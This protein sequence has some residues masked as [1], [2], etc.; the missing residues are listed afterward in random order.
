MKHDVLVI[1]G[2]HAGCE[3]AAA[4]A[5][6]GARVALITHDAKTIGAMS[7]NPSI[8]GVG[9]G[10]LVRE[11]DALDGLIARAGDCAAIHY[12]M[13]NRSKGAAVRGPRIQ[14][15]RRAF[16]AA[17]AAMIAAEPSIEV[18]QAEVASLS[19][20][21]GRCGGVVTADGIVIDARSVVLAA[22]TFLNGLLYRGRERASGGRW[23]EPASSQLGDQLREAGL[24]IGRM[25]TGTPPRLDGRTIDWSRLE[26]Q[27]GDI[28]PWT[29]SPMGRRTLPQLA[30]AITRTTMATHDAIRAGLVDSPL[31]T[32]AISGSGPRYCPSI[33]DKVDR[34]GDR[35]GHQ[36]FLEPEALGSHLVYPNGLSTSLD[37]KSQ[38]AFVTT[39]AGLERAAIVLP[40]YAVEYDH[41]D[42]RALGR[43][44]N[45]KAI[46]GLFC[47]GQINGTTGYEEAAAQGLVAGVNAAAHALDLSPI[48]FDR[49]RSYIGVLV[50]DL[51]L[52]GV[53]EPYRMLTSRA[54]HRLVLRADNAATRLTPFGIEAGCVGPNRRAEWERRVVQLDAAR[55]GVSDVALDVISEVE[56]DRHYAP[57][58]ER[59]RVEQD[60]LE[61]NDPMPLPK[62]DSWHLAGLS[63]EMAER[64]GAAQPATLGEARR[65]RGMT[66]AAL[67]TLLVTGRRL[68]G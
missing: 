40:G 53:S 1:G 12:R 7:C 17:I 67:A 24:P 18:I 35:D 16:A 30:C 63:N 66:P 42:P 45:V 5:R 36:V 60:R 32:G 22:G 33:E 56:T 62:R 68:R 47:A 25:K 48:M 37:R 41:I 13:L 64:L 8:G 58:V 31:A 2:G 59:Q 27:P 11:V 54:E 4:A 23:S 61:A 55:A 21:S 29:L 26:P 19:L 34:F 14:A 44:L 57:Y 43:A 51:I 28:E 50:D 20:H 52:Q 65:I 49:D 15:D 39:I 6:K 38:Q 3:A 46:E 10:H 9:K